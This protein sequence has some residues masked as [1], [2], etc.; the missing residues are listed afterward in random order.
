MTSA[1]IRVL[2]LPVGDAVVRGDDESSGDGECKND[3]CKSERDGMVD[4]KI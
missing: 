2:R 1:F 3:E 4:K